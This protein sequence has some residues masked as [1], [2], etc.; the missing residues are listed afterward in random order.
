MSDK[1]KGWRAKTM[2]RKQKKVERAT[3]KVR[4]RTMV[5][6]RFIPPPDYEPRSFVRLTY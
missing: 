3:G 5:E 4:R 6:V 2:I 1:R